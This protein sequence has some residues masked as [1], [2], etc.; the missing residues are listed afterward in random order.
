MPDLPGENRDRPFHSRYRSEGNL[1]ENFQLRE[2]SNRPFFNCSND[3]RYN[4]GNA[5][6]I[7]SLVLDSDIASLISDG[8]QSRV[9]GRLGWA[10]F[11][12]LG[13]S[14]CLSD[15]LCRGPLL[16]GK[17]IYCVVEKKKE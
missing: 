8:T 16:E 10:R 9:L 3:W 11:E 17:G 13:F 5:K 1:I 12:M 2:L 7:E 6:R 15:N 4:Q 14:A